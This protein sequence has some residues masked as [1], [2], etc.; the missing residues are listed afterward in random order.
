M[1]QFLEEIKD[2]R[3]TLSKAIQRHMIEYSRTPIYSVMLETAGRLDVFIKKI[4]RGD[5]DE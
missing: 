3:Q 5:Y 2:L 1:K 4:E